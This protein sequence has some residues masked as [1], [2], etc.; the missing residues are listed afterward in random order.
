MLVRAT[1]RLRQSSI[2]PADQEIR[3]CRATVREGHEDLSNAREEQPR[4]FRPGASARHG[5]RCE[6]VSSSPDLATKLSSL[7][8][9]LLTFSATHIGKGFAM[10]APHPDT[11]DRNLA[12][13]ERVYEELGLRTASDRQRY[14]YPVEVKRR[15]VFDVTISTSSTPF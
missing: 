6:T 13:I 2:S 8:Y 10:T 1:G 3:R 15:P 12:S 5:C 14:T 7:G 4:A 11:Q 9:G